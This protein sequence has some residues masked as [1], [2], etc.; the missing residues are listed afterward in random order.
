MFLRIISLHYAMSSYFCFFI[1]LHLSCLLL[2]LVWCFHAPPYFNF[3]KTGM[4]FLRSKITCA[5]LFVCLCNLHFFHCI[6]VS[7]G[8]LC[9]HFHTFDTDNIT[10]QN[11]CSRLNSSYKFWKAGKVNQLRFGDWREKT[12]VGELLMMLHIREA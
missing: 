9:P 2:S 6:N 12:S 4:T 11:M 10:F 1:Q 3:I 7:H 5:V 8:V